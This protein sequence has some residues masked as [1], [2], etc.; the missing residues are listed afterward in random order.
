MTRATTPKSTRGVRNSR[1]HPQSGET[2]IASFAG[3]K[4]SPRA[5]I[6]PVEEFLEAGK[7]RLAGDI[8]WAATTDEVKQ[9]P[10]RD[11]GL[12]GS[13]CR[14]GLMW[15]NTGLPGANAMR[16]VLA[17]GC[18]SPSVP[19]PTPQSCITTTARGIRA[20]GPTCRFPQELRC[21]RLDGGTDTGV[22]G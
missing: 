17:L 15:H 7:R 5:C 6:T 1:L 8:A 16:A 10:A 20:R 19:L 21:S 22:E 18:S 9:L 11:A 3:A 2:P 12:E 4:A 13:R 14:A